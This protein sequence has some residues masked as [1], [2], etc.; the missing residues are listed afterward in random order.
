MQWPC[1]CRSHSRS[2]RSATLGATQVPAAGAWGNW[3]DLLPA[4]L[5]QFLFV[6]LGEEPGW[7]GFMLPQL[8][9][10]YSTFVSSLIVGVVWAVWHAPFY[11]SQVPVDQVAPFILNVVTA[12]VL[13]AW[14]YNNSRAS[15]LVCMLLHAVTNAAGGGYV[16]RVL[17]SRDLVHWWWAYSLL[18]ILVVAILVWLTGPSLKGRTAA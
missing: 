2:A 18:S 11:G 4:F 7:R 3:T 8:Q 13:I 12:S 10:T 5:S 15:V 17:H 1:S 9:R 14:L 6:G 16:A